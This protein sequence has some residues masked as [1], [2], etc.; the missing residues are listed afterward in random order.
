[1]WQCLTSS[2]F[3][4]QAYVSEISDALVHA[5]GDNSD[6]LVRIEGLINELCTVCARL[7]ESNPGAT[8]LLH[9]QGKIGTEAD[10]VKSCQQTLVSIPSECKS[11]ARG[12]SC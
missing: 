12:T 2:L 8:S 1:M 4:I 11:R 7:S 5:Q 10:E 9:A 3:Q 6:A